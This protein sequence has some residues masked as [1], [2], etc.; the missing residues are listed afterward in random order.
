MS[1]VRLTPVICPFCGFGC[2]LYVRSIDGVP[3]GIEFYDKGGVNEGKLCPKGVAAVDFLRHPERLRKPLR[4]V[5]ERGEGR[6]KEI[7]WS[8]AIKEVA[9][10]LKEIKKV[11]GAESVGFLSSARCTN[12]ENY[13]MQKLARLYGSGNIDHCARLCHSATVAGLIKCLGAGAQSSP[14]TDILKTR[15]IL[16]W[17]YNPAETHPLLMRYVLKAKDLGAKLIVVD[18]RRTRTARFADIHL[19]IRPGTD[20]ALANAMMNV[21]ISN[22]LYDRDFI[23]RRTEGF[24]ELKKLVMKYTPKYAEEVTGVTAALIDEAARTFASAGRGVIMWAMG[25]TQHTVGT[26]NVVALADLALLCGYVGREGCGVYP[27]RGQNNVQGACDMGA[28]VEFLPGYRPA[29]AEEKRREV[30]KLWGVDELPEP[31]LTVVEMVNEAGSGRIKAMY[32]MGENPVVSDPNTSHVIKALNNLEFLVVQDIFLTE[33]AAYADIVL[34]AAAYAEK[35][36]SL[37]SSERRVQWSFKAAEPPGEARPDWV[38][39]SSVARELGLKGFNY[40]SPEDILREIN[41]VVPQYRG[42]T[43]ERLKSS[44]EGVFWP[45]PSE[46]HPGTMRLYEERFLTCNGKAKLVGVEHREPAE[47]P[48]R[49]YP[50]ILTTVRVVGQYHTLTMT[51]RSLSLVRRWPEPYVEVNP[52]DARRYGVS[53]GDEVYVVTRRGRY[54]CKVKV[55]S[56]IREG[57]VAIPWHWGANIL[58]IDA[59][60]P[61]CKIPEY[62]VCACRIERVGGG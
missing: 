6:F 60:D 16:V 3:A 38:I 9:T 10:R 62:K 24:E 32:I 15:V 18:P 51:G 59:L 44:P 53:D 56:S 49:E 58:T 14:F 45:C 34:P 27:M 50:L 17:G 11:F 19:Q 4:R 21:I 39:L 26:Y 30:A 22:D 23:V 8:E 25:L 52:E 28:L 13:L 35:E 20:I 61:T 31:G 2:K 48:D 37:T 7:S 57:V 5:G 33:T 12:E 41:A 54:K 1:E 42:I 43:P 40:S 36:G 47:K 29:A 55:T 46:G